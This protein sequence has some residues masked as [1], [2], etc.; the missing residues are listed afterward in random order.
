MKQEW[1]YKE[2]R[3]VCSVDNK[4]NTK[5]GIP[6]I[7]MEDIEANSSRFL[8]SLEPRSVKSNTF[9]FTG[10]QLLYGRLRPYL[11]KVFLPDF[12]GHCST[13]IFTININVDLVRRY[14]YYW[15]IQDSTVSRINE[16]CT[17]ARMPRAN[18]EE[19]FTFKLPIPPLPEQQRIVAILD[20]AFAAIETAKANTEK[21]LQNVR[22]LFETFLDNAFKKPDNGRWEKRKLLDLCELGD[23]NHGG[24]YPKKSDMRKE[25]VPF[26]R[27]VNF[28]NGRISTEEMHYIS[29]AKHKSLKKGHLQTGDV[30]FTNRG[31]IGKCA[32]VDE[33]YNDA[34]LNSQIAYFRC[35]EML[36]NEFLYYFLT[37]PEI[38]RFVKKSQTGAALQ[39]FT[40]NS[41]SKLYIHL[42]SIDEQ[43]QI[44]DIVNRVIK[45]TK[46][47]ESVYIL[48]LVGLDELKRSIL[49]KAFNG[50]F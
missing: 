37:S 1:V 10:K 20:Q 19:V 29:V 38:Q 34:N 25:G 6:Y 18:M 4:K 50:E 33:N 30:L 42:P 7:G 11:N 32:I 14:L 36:N 48:K 24:N 12:E 31:I 49:Q 40:Q 8:G 26:I 47:L 15:F 39:Q 41:I 3:D 17:G 28:D 16:T 46:K 27:G 43:K 45:E 5:K 9:Y 2:L 23:G 22:E 44:V 35:S 13:E 21:N